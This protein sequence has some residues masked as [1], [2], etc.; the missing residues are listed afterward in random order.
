MLTLRL[1]KRLAQRLGVR[2]DKTA[3]E[4]D[5]RLGDWFANMIHEPLPVVV[6]TNAPTRLALVVPALDAA[7]VVRQFRMR[8]ANLLG[9]LGVPDDAV[10]AEVASTEPVAFAPTNDRRVLGSLNDICFHVA[11][12][13]VDCGGM[14]R[15]SELFA[16]ERQLA[17][18]PHVKLAES[19]P[20]R[21]VRAIL[22]GADPSL[23]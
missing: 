13:L 15:E 16:L 9:G 10:T 7:E 23:H 22:G 17:G 3:P 11:V 21:A 6:C 20:E 8:L 1:T 5:G 19:I 18:M 12:G 4:S 14:V 2:L